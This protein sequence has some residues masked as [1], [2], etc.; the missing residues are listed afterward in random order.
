MMTSLNLIYS[1]ASCSTCRKAIKWLREN[2]IEFELID[3][4]NTPPS[5]ETL[6]KAYE[7]LGSRKALFNTSGLSYRTLGAAKVNSM[8]DAE[9]LESLSSDG[10]LIKRPLLITAEGKMLVGFKQE[11]WSE[12]LLK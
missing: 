4:V 7:Q 8:S 12:I 9:A 11:N 2:N 6:R 10:K 1:Y 5:T 3:I